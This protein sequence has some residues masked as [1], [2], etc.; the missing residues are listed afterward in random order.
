MLTFL[1]LP[2]LEVKIQAL[3]SR[4]DRESGILSSLQEQLTD[5]Q[6]SLEST[7]RD[8]EI[9]EQVQLLFTKTSEF[10]RAQTKVHV[11]RAVTAALQA[12]ISRDIRFEILLGEFNGQP[13]ADWKVVGTMKD[14]TGEYTVSGNPENARG[15]GIADIVSLALRLA[16]LELVRPK[17]EGPIILDEPGKHVS[18]EYREAFGEFLRSYARQSG[19]Q[20][21]FVTNVDELSAAADVAYRVVLKNGVSEVTRL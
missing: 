10:A 15:G 21:I 1:T 11:E 13:A 16:M 6:E 14:E 5:K 12:V 20:I 9:G 19:R 2:V 4:Y 7:N 3:Q 17:P 8:I 18:P